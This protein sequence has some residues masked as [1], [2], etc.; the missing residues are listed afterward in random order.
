VAFVLTSSIV[1]VRSTPAATPVAPA[2][3][4]RMS[5]RT[6]PESISALAT[7]PFAVF[8]PSAGYGPAVSSGMTLQLA[9]AVVVPVA[10]DVVAGVVVEPLDA[11]LAAALPT[12]VAP[13]PEP[14]SASAPATARKPGAPGNRGLA[15]HLQVVHK[16][17]VVVV[18][19]GRTGSISLV[20]NRV[21]GHRRL[22]PGGAR[23]DD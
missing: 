20:Q 1:T 2:M 5:L 21:C 19:A 13:P 9:L 10:G 11:S 6:M 3:L 12:S 18:A 16:A 14:N 23:C 4:L 22:L 15:Q 8:D 17:A 7:A